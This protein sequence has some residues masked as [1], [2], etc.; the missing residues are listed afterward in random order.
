MFYVFLMHFIQGK[1]YQG[2]LISSSCD[3]G[4]GQFE[5]DGSSIIYATS[6]PVPM[7]DQTA[8]A[9]ASF[10]IAPTLSIGI[11]LRALLLVGFSSLA[12][13]SLVAAS[14][15]PLSPVGDGTPLPACA[16]SDGFLV[17]VGVVPDDAGAVVF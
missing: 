2:N 12:E 10:D 17:G 3:N 4:H 1:Q 14:G 13:V 16:V 5:N 11:R 15:V 7:M 9:T 6:A 8:A